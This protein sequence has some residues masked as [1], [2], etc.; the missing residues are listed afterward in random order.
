MRAALSNQSHAFAHD[1]APAQA[2]P[3]LGQILVDQ[4]A[5]SPAT[6]AQALDRQSHLQ[7][8]LGE[9]LI[10][11]GH[12]SEAVVMRAL[13][14]QQGLYQV[15][16]A[17]EPG[18]PTLLSLADRTVWLRH[19]CLPWMR[20]GG[21]VMIATAQ[22]D[23]LVAL[24]RA[25][26]P[27]APPL[28]PVIA[29][30]RA[31]MS[32]L[33]H[34]FRA[35]MTAA[36]ET[37]VAPAYSCRHWQ[38]A[39][40][41]SV[42][43]KALIALGCVTGL[44]LAP[45]WVFTLVAALAMCSLFCI[46]GLKLTAALAQLRAQDRVTD[47]APLPNGPLPRISVMVPLFK[48]TEIASALI[49]RLQR[50]R[51][52][53]ALLDVILVLEEKDTQTRATLESTTLPHWMHVVEVPDG[54]GITTK[55]RALNYALDFC[56][57]EI[58]GIWD[59]E[60]APEPDQLH[61]VAAGFARAAPDVV[62][63]QGILDYYNP[64]ANWIARC[65]TL[66][67]ASW[68]RIVVPGLARLGLV[69]PLGGTTLFLRRDKIL[70]MGGWDAHNVTEDADLGVRI[71]RF[72]Y[73]TEFIQTATHEEANCRPWRWVKQR[74][75][76]LKGFMVTYLVHMRDPRG[77]IADIGWRKFLG[78]QAFF[79]GTLSQ[80]LLAPVLWSFW[81]HA[82]AL[83]HPAQ[84]V[85]DASLMVVVMSLFLV[86]ELVNLTVALCAVSGPAHRFLM[87]WAVTLPLYFPLGAVASYKALYELALKPFYWDKTQHGHSAPQAKSGH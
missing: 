7:L 23:T 17:Q 68:F 67:Y 19:R 50:L 2:R 84:S 83:P 44:A 20:L 64:R 46:T 53:K 39:R 63:L 55:P 80:F 52:P 22:P 59:A 9:V 61:K 62:C 57:G 13:A 5:I 81:L 85:F 25:L 35:E 31:V 18:D 27:D 74:S 72:G 38:P 45:I 87:P 51:Y 10:D 76:W 75:R 47:A 16:L 4:G 6:L 71:A 3:P 32:A 12:V 77:L 40:A 11:G 24:R 37:R 29:R 33:S 78:L 34:A 73:R 42:A 70:E 49:T 79:I 30:E 54:G 15:D 8:P 14:Q 21:A 65:F 58:I 41:G 60:D 36:A 1:L 56:R 66:E 86:T 69:I 48:E 82:L 43:L 26:G 28:L